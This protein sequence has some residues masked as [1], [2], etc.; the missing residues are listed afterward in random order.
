MEPVSRCAEH[1]G[2]FEFPVKEAIPCRDAADDL[3]RLVADFSVSELG[4]QWRGVKLI[5]GPEPES[6]PQIEGGLQSLEL[7]TG[8]QLIVLFGTLVDL[9]DAESVDFPQ[10]LL[11]VVMDRLHRRQIGR[12][13]RLEL[14]AV[15]VALQILTDRL[16]EFTDGFGPCFLLE[17]NSVGV[18]L[19]ATLARPRHH[20]VMQE[21]VKPCS[22]QTVA[23]AD[24]VV[25]KRQRQV[26][27]ERFDPQRQPAQ[28]DGQRVQ[29]DAVDAAFD[30]VPPQCCPDTWLEIVI[31]RPARQRLAGQGFMVLV[32]INQIEHGTARMFANPVVNDQR[33]VQSSGQK[34]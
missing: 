5:G 19:V 9:R 22:D 25:E 28:L 16:C 33:F 13:H 23:A 14:T 12:V 20:R 17:V 18:V 21:L 31:V 1:V 6:A 10:R 24:F 2:E 15:D 26:A 3:A 32:C 7:G 30:D 27:V 29:I 11:G 8:Q 34:P 4:G